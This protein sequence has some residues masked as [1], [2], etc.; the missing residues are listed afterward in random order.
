MVDANQKWGVEEA[1]ARTRALAPIQPWWMEEPTSPDDILGHARI[2]R[3]AAPI[4]IATGEHVQNR[5][6]FKQLLQANAIDV[7]PARL[8]P[9]VAEVDEEASPSSSSPPNSKSP[10]APTPAV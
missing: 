1:I 4:R 6:I 2:R 7:L 3:E 9:C 5:V 8:L 10:S